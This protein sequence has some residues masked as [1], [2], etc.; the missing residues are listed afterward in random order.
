MLLLCK[1][2]SISTDAQLQPDQAG[3]V[4]AQQCV[5]ARANTYASSMASFPHDP[6]PHRSTVTGVQLKHAA[7]ASCLTLLSPSR[8]DFEAV[9]ERSVAALYIIFLP[10][11]VS[12]SLKLFGRQL[13]GRTPWPWP[14]SRLWRHVAC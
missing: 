9:S 12:H 1:Y 3:T 8:Q 6:T 7:D 4:L 14:P 10:R 2:F 5:I 13:D 11:G